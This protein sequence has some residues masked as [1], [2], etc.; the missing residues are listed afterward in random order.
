MEQTEMDGK[1]FRLTL[2][3]TYGKSDQN[4]GV[5]KLAQDACTINCRQKISLVNPTY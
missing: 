1:D 2:S 3:T 5:R 4:Q